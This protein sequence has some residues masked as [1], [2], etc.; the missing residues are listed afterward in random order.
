MPAA[1]R[2]RGADVLARLERDVIDLHPRAAVVLAGVNDIAGGTAEQS[3]VDNLV[4]MVDQLT[5]EGI[6][7]FVLGMLPWTKRT[8]EQMEQR[9]LINEAVAN[10]IGGRDLD[11]YFDL[12]SLVGVYRPGGPD[13]NLWDIRP[14]FEQDGIHLTRVGYIAAGQALA[15]IVPVPSAGVLAVVGVVVVLA[16]RFR[17][18]A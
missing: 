9:D 3:T 4:S 17:L 11:H 14:E 18:V 15:A 6:T 12:S 8:T 5:G 2:I 1:H 13:G 10:A 7:A 16:F